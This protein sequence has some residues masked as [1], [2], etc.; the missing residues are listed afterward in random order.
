MIIANK[1]QYIALTTILKEDP[2]IKVGEAAIKLER[3]LLAYKR[4]I[5]AVREHR[6]IL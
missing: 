1:L 4:A 3:K 2:T 5:Q 6:G